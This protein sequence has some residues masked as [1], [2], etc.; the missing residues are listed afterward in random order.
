MLHLGNYRTTFMKK[1]YDIT[2]T[3]LVI[4]DLDE[5]F[6]HGNISEGQVILKPE[7]IALVRE[8]TTKGIMNSI[9]SKNDFEQVKTK[10]IELGI[11][12]VWD[13][14]VFP[15]I[16]WTPK[17]KRIQNI[18]QSMNLRTENVIFIDDNS[19]NINEAKFY[20]PSIM[21][22]TP[23]FI[24]KIAE[25][26]YLVNDYDFEHTRLKQYKILEEKAEKLAQ[27]SSN[28]DFLCSSDIKI[29]IKKDCENNLERIKKL[30][31]RTN[32][33]NFT[34]FR[35]KNLEE[36]IKNNESAYIIAEDKYGNYGICGFYSLDKKQNKL[37]HFLFSCR[38]M[39][40]GIEQ[41]IYDYLNC[42]EIDIQGEVASDLNTQSDWIKIVDNLEP[43][44]IK[45]MA[46]NGVNILFKGPCDLCSALSY[47]DADCN[48]DTEFPYW[49]KQLVYILAHTH[50]AFI[51]QTHRLPSEKLKE[52][53]MRFPYPNPDEFKTKFFDKKYNIIFLSL[54]TVT[55]SG[56]YIN[57]TDGTYAFFGFANC[58]ITDSKNWGKILAPIPAE[59]RAQNILMLEEFRKNYVF[60][61]NP[62]VDLV[63]KNL[64]YILKNISGKLVLILGSETPTN[65]IQAGYENMAERHEILNQAIRKNF[66]DN[67]DFIEL[68]DF[69]KTDEDY[70]TCINHFSRKVYVDLAKKI[71]EITNKKLGCNLLAIK[72]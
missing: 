41:F 65:K 55:H 44:S 10:F 50:T 59:A 35:D 53:S 8:L 26:L 12:D 48:I 43:K 16:D 68:T 64:S 66:K 25:E 71:V 20:S 11:N 9:C 17:G 22:A 7:T 4:W 54:L 52:L 36:T 47:I 51:E 40:M 2:K 61:G 69:I 32:Q 67:V 45:K 29:C 18:I 3:K 63:I 31:L 27:A 24:S 34:K 46:D 56:I 15:S 14:F 23:E 21:S 62:P 6:W 39:N 42:P 19:S 33:L 58:D 13:L 49:N 37:I 38:I 5:T 30:I 60:G 28:E 1:N 70:T 57:K 72:K